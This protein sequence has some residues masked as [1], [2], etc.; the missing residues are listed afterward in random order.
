MVANVFFT[1]LIFSLF[2]I[3]LSKNKS[4]HS[5][6]VEGD[7][8]S[9]RGEIMEHSLKISVSKQ[10]Q[11]GGVVRFRNIS[12]RERI[13]RFLFGAKQKL[14]IIVPGDTVHELAISEV[15]GGDT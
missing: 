3:N 13:L 6:K 11:T 7:D 10:P 9:E 4:S 14:T 8:P 2:F 15:K 5:Y 12:V 1:P